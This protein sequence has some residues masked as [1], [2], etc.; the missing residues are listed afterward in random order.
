MLNCFASPDVLAQGSVKWSNMQS[1]TRCPLREQGGTYFFRLSNIF[2][3]PPTKI[4]TELLIGVWFKFRDIQYLLPSALALTCGDKLC[5]FTTGPHGFHLRLARLGV[6]SVHC[7]MV[8]KSWE[9]FMQSGNR[10]N[11]LFALFCSA[12]VNTI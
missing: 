7:V 8:T 12:R 3:F 2:V 10:L 6:I 4:R 11:F 1:K 9:H 5:Y